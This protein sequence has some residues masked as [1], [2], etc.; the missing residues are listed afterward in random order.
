MSQIE[1]D[2][3][4]TR[5]HEWALVDEDHPNVVIVGITDYAQ[6]KLGDIVMVELPTVGDKIEQ[7]ETCGTVES[8]K[9]VSDLFAP[10]TGKVV[11]VNEALTDSP[12]LVN[13][14]CYDEG[15]LFKVEL[16]DKSEL[17]DLM[18]AREYEAFLNSLDED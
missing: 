13:E 6:D 8:P 16:A 5:E 1:K 17:D 3:R 9:S 14:D 4:Y 18:D 7:D 15:W 12:E 10:V 11:E 2:R